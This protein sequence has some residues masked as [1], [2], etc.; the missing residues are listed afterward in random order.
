[1]IGYG[2]VNQQRVYNLK[3][4]R[5]YFSAFVWFNEGLCYYDISHEIEDKDDDG[6]KLGDI[7]NEVDDE[8]FSKVMD[9]KQVVERDATLTYSIPQS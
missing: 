1:M 3:T 6:A 9:R 4:R 5:I 7:W 2:G 8:E